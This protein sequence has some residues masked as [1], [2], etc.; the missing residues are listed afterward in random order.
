MESERVFAIKS[1]AALN[2]PR[3]FAIKSRAAWNLH[4]FLL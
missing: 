2:L 3:V 1:G 4:R